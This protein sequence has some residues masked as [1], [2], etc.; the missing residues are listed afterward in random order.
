MIGFILGC[1][2]GG[3]TVFVLYAVILVGTRDDR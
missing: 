3:F 2:V 1:F